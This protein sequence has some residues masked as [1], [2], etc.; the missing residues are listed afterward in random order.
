[1]PGI[2]GREALN[3]I[4]ARRNEYVFTSILYPH[5]SDHFRNTYFFVCLTRYDTLHMVGGSST[6]C[7]SVI[8]ILT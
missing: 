3:M 7:V 4:W 5:N 6:P 8:H 2:V 1:M